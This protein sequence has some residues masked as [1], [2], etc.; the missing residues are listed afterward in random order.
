[1]FKP[2]PDPAWDYA[3]AWKV[4]REVW[5]LLQEKQML[6]LSEKAE[7]QN[8]EVDAELKALRHAIN[9][10]LDELGSLPAQE[11]EPNQE[12]E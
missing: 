1:M 11:T 6:L 9:A 8:P 7:N 12:A 2:H 5:E 3:Y 4:G 10:K